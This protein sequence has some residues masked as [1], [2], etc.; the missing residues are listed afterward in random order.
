M[1]VSAKGC[2]LFFIKLSE[3][4]E[5]VDYTSFASSGLTQGPSHRL[6]P[7]LHDLISHHC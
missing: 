4:H 5:S 3:S 1:D 7:D 6:M 2:A